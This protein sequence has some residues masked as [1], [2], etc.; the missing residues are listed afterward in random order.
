M[1]N[2]GQTK[3]GG[4]VQGDADLRVNQYFECRISKCK[5]DLVSCITPMRSNSLPCGHYSVILF[6]VRLYRGPSQR[7]FAPRTLATA[8]V[9]L[10]LLINWH[11]N[12]ERQISCRQTKG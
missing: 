5:I 6:L 3:K 1:S 11:P 10:A 4:R 7:L 12:R 8:C 2:L 9:K